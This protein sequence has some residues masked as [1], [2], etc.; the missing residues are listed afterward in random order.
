MAAPDIRP[1]PFAQIAANLQGLS[2]GLNTSAAPHSPLTM[3]L[4]ERNPNTIL[5][6]ADK[7]VST[8]SLM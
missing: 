4:A 2:K 3:P 5:S 6:P 1:D 8:L 7:V